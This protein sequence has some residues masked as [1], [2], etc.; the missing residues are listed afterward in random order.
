MVKADNEPSK[1][2][3]D[4]TGQLIAINRYEIIGR[5]ASG[6]IHDL[7]NG[8]GVLYG[9]LEMA[10]EECPVTSPFINELRCVEKAA[11]KARLT[12]E[13]FHSLTRRVDE[14]L[15]RLD[16]AAESRALLPLIETLFPSALTVDMQGPDCHLPVRGKANLWRQALLAV[17]LN[18]REAM[19][20]GG[21]IRVQMKASDGPS[22][23]TGYACVEVSDQGPGLSASQQQQ[24]FEPL[25]AMAD[26][27]GFG[28]PAARAIARTM[29]GELQIENLPGK[30][31]LVRFLIPL[32]M[33]EAD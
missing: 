3:A 33:V 25:F 21:T 17:L 26:G 19:S 4:L 13:R 2:E 16:L 30:G 12:V 11:D 28:L 29:G 22:P 6:F 15:R 7:N 8:L 20:Q 18:A 10:L 27:A 1:P 31:C 24:A 5:L 32:E 23:L 9:Y 14:P